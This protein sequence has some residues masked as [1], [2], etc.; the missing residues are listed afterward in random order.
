MVVNVANL[1]RK[2]AGHQLAARIEVAPTMLA[3]ATLGAVS[4]AAHSAK[5]PTLLQVVEDAL[6]GLCQFL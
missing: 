5:V 6:F 2:L 1:D 4:V 3:P